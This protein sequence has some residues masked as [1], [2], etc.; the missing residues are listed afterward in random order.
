VAFVKEV[1]CGLSDADVGFYAYYH[2]VKGGWEGG[3]SRAD[4]GC[5][6]W[7]CQSVTLDMR[8]R[9]IDGEVRLKICADG[10]QTQDR[11]CGCEQ[12]RYM[13]CTHNIENSVLSACITVLIPPGASKPS[14]EHVSPSRALFWVVAKTGMLRIW[15]NVLYQRWSIHLRRLKMTRWE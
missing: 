3:D 8:L 5:A 14:S 1:E 7:I 6:E 4:F 9:L 13:V 15:P 2:A 12:D 10:L 11:R